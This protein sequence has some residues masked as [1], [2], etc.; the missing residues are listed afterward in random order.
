MLWSVVKQSRIL[1]A[2]KSQR[3]LFLE[4]ILT[5]S[6]LPSR[7]RDVPWRAFVPYRLFYQ[8]FWSSGMYKRKLL[9]VSTR[10]PWG[11]T[12]KCVRRALEACC[13][14]PL[15]SHSP[16]ITT[17]RWATIQTRIHAGTRIRFYG[18]WTWWEIVC[19]GKPSGE[20]EA[21]ADNA[22][23]CPPVMLIGTMDGLLELV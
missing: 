7:Y 17:S 1:T 16:L 4:F 18:R 15:T 23:L 2:S 6:R 13:V 3:V 9:E 21:F 11:R 12:S 22:P 19:E 5:S 20:M 8:S 10:S 14:E